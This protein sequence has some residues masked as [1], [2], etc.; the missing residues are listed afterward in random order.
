MNSIDA[1]SKFY[2]KAAE[3]SPK[4]NPMCNACSLSARCLSEIL[5]YMLAVTK[6]KKVSKLK[7]KVEEWE[8][9]SRDL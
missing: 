5:N 2:K 8:K 9:K 3:V 4:D 7:G 1:A 6:Q